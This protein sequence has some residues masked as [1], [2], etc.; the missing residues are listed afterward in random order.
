M[1][2]PDSRQRRGTKRRAEAAGDKAP[3]SDE[4]PRK[5]R[6]TA[7]PPLARRQPEELVASLGAISLAAALKGRTL[8]QQ[9]RSAVGRN[10]LNK[11]LAMPEGARLLSEPWAYISAVFLAFTIP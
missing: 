2:M 5:R 1:Q 10:N 4:R 3:G 8:V 7:A 11:H 6:A 9:W